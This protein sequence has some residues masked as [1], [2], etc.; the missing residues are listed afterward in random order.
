MFA[1]ILRHNF[2]AHII[3]YPGRFVPRS[4]N[5]LLNYD[6]MAHIYPLDDDAE[7]TH[8]REY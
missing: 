1:R 4:S 2:I 8:S 5:L 7:G 6:N 3:R